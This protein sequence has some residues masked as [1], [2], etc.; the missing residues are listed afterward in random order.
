[1]CRFACLTQDLC[2][3]AVLSERLEALADVV[4]VT[5]HIGE[6]THLANAFEHALAVLDV[7]LEVPSTL[8]ELLHQADGCERLFILA[9][10]PRMEDGAEHHLRDPA[11]HGRDET[12]TDV[13][14][15]FA[16]GWNLGTHVHEEQCDTNAGAQDTEGDGTGL[17]PGCEPGVVDGAGGRLVDALNEEDRPGDGPQDRDSHRCL[18]SRRVGIHWR[19]AE[20]GVARWRSDF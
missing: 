18:L 8:F 15:E 4:E 14:D 13:V 19:L 16:R 2:G 17:E 3:I 10:R 1:M 12:H 7:A 11:L 20:A 9:T 6:A 5:L